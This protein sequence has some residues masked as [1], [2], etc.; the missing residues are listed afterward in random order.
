M[1]ALAQDLAPA[2]PKPCKLGRIIDRLNKTDAA[3]LHKALMGPPALDG[4]LGEQKIAD[5]LTKNGHGVSD[6]TVRLHR[7]RFCSC[8][9]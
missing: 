1:S 4:G 7:M 3:A 5:A 8:F 9:R 6:S 2:T